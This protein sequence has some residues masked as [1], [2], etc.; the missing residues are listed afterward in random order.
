MVPELAVA[1]LACARIGAVHSIVFAGFS[2]A[3]IAERNND[4]SAKLQITADGGWRRGKQLPLKANVDVALKKSPTVEKCIVLRRVGCEVEMRQGRD[5]WWDEL[6]EDASAECPAEPIDSND[7][8]FILYTSGSTGKPKGIKH[9]TGGYNLYAKKTM[10]WVF[11]IRDDD[12]YWCTADVGW[13]TGHTYTVYGP[14]T[15]GATSLMYEGAPNWPD[16]G[17]FWEIV[18]KYRISIFYTAP[19]A[20]RSFIKWGDEDDE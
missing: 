20:I 9:N 18:E 15:A 16:E 13:I 14:L 12:V 2:A 8:L 4:A 7:T 19:T 6:M 3:A 10:Q 11:D 17:R 1:M 5:F